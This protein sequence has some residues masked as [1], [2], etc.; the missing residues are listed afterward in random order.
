LKALF[1]NGGGREV[2]RFG[3]NPSVSYIIR[4]KKLKLGVLGKQMVKGRRRKWVEGVVRRVFN[5]NENSTTP[6]KNH[7]YY[8]RREPTLEGLQS[9]TREV[10]DKKR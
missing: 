10:R 2:K 5:I 9:Q 1:G 7:H 4:P 3:G 8:Q 6:T